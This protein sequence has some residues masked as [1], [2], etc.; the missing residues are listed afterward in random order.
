MAKIIK[1]IIIMLLVCLLT[2]L[3]L[4]IALYQYSPNRKA[5][6]EVTTY[7]ATS[8]VQDLLEDDIDTRSQKTKVVSTYEVTSNDLAGY[9]KSNSYVP[10]KSNPFA[11]AATSDGKGENDNNGENTGNNGDTE[12]KKDEKKN[13]TLPS[14]YKQ[15]GTK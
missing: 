5:I 4:A 1:E 15:N 3:L 12:K 2:L 10:G 6:P 11:P 8:E 14:V 13:T 7:A 9:Q